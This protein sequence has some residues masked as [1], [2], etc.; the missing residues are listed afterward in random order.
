MSD[1]RF[2]MPYTYKSLLV[3]LGIIVVFVAALRFTHCHAI[4]GSFAFFLFCLASKRWEFA[5]ISFIVFNTLQLT[6]AELFEY[7][8]SYSL[9]T[10][11]APFFFSAAGFFAANKRNSRLSPFFSL[12]YIYMFWMMLVSLGGWA[13]IIS[14]LKAVFFLAFILAFIKGGELVLASG[15]EMGMTVRRVR[16]MMLA[17]CSY[18]ILGSAVSYFIPSIGYSMMVRSVERYG[19]DWENNISA[20]VGARLFSG[21][22]MHSQMLGPLMAILSAFLISDY[23]TNIRRKSWIHLVLITTAPVLIYLSDS[24]TA[25][26]AYVLSIGAMVVFAMRSRAISN[27]RRS[28]FV[29]VVCAMGVAGIVAAAVVP[30]IREKVI[31]FVYKAE[32]IDS[33]EAQV[34]E[35][36]EAAWAGS[37]MPAVQQM[38]KNFKKRPWMG[39]GFQ[40][41]EFSQAYA[42]RGGLILSAPIEKGVLFVAVFEEGGFPGAILFF[43]FIVAVYQKGFRSDCFCFLSVLTTILLCNLGEATFFSP[44]SS[45]GVCWAVCICSL[46]MDKARL[47]RLAAD[48]HVKAAYGCG[49]RTA[50]AGRGG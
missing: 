17:I 23:L 7:G 46:L 47:I 38:W 5:F 3:C 39:N 18:Y 6:C 44:S 8:V 32:D 9:V 50:Y 10:K 40:V 43:A 36:G 30:Q 37:R 2:E 34:S 27:A 12:L 25:L 11:I 29:S 42:D 49:L 45:G 22:T 4:W 14:E 15:L 24:R 21:I 35:D 20:G 16:A 26:G 48:G 33:V 19:G 41:N 31:Q 28:A 1:S 13:P